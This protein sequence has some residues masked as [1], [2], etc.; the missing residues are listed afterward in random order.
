MY[1]PK[2]VASELVWLEASSSS[3]DSETESDVSDLQASQSTS[4]A[5]PYIVAKE[6]NFAE[7]LKWVKANSPFLL[8]EPAT[9]RHSTQVRLFSQDSLVQKE[10]MSLYL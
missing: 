10:C 6:I 4:F 2:P 5:P 8:S 3:S 1:V 9:T 7:L